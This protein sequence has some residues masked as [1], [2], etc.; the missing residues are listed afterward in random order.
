MTCR[1]VGD[2]AANLLPMPIQRWAPWPVTAALSPLGGNNIYIEDCR[3]L[4]YSV[5]APQIVGGNGAN[6]LD[7]VLQASPVPVEHASRN[8]FDG[9]DDGHEALFDGAASNLFFAIPFTTIGACTIY[10]I[11]LRLSRLGT[12]A[13]AGGGTPPCVYVSIQG[14]GGGDPDGTNVGGTSRGVPTA[15]IAV[16]LDEYV[17]TFEIGVDLAAL[18]T[19]WIVISPDYDTDIANLINVHYNTHA[20]GCKFFDAAW[21]V[22]VNQDIWYT[23]NY[24]IY[25]TV[26]K[27]DIEGGD[28]PT[29]TE[30]SEVNMLDWWER[31]EVN[32]SACSGPFVR[33]KFSVFGAGSIVPS[34]VINAGDPQVR[35]LTPPN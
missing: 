11:R 5:T 33:F 22:M 13:K 28:I 3:A 10:Q 7:M 34:V 12:P 27:T 23:M 31:R 26:S 18:T 30:D 19:Y 4:Q 14:N 21:A 32:V 1:R 16:T 35:P 17:F 29:F 20:S 9:I 8:T 6:T 15:D 2:Y 25:T 24:L